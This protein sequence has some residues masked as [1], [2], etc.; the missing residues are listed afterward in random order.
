[1][2]IVCSASHAQMPDKFTNLQFFPKDI[3]KK[4]LVSTMRGFSFA[5]GVRCEHCHLQKA[6]KTMDF[7]A[8]DKQEKKTARLMLRMVTA[9]NGDYISKVL[10]PTP[11]AR[12]ECVTCHHG[13]A[14][15]RTINSVLLHTI[16]TKDV[17]TAIAQYR[18]LRKQ[19]YGTARYDFGETPLNILTEALMAKERNK[20]AAAIEELNLELNAPVTA[21][22]LHLAG[23]AH[24]A[25][26]DLEKAKA[27]YQD[28]LQL[29]PKD[30]WA[31]TQLSEL[32]A[33]DQNPPKGHK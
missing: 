1:M 29:D 11:P 5:L 8:D 26:G 16:T 33:A 3:A 10:T 23:M 9:I 25:S 17:N 6:D 18:D 24:R 20:D 22:S 2:F 28:A 31:K 15:P 4:E 27:N 30:T 19:Y 14:E 21:W 7:A 13:L 12:V 32:A